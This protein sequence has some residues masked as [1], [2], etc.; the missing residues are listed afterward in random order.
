M[1]CVVVG[2]GTD[3]GKTHVTACLLAWAR[4]HAR[5]A[6]GYKPIAT[7]VDQRCEDAEAHA[8]AAG[9]PLIP[10]TFTY[11][12]PISPHLAAREE[13]RPIDVDRI[14][15]RTA[16][17][18]RE[19]DHVLVETAGGLFSPVSERL[20]NVDVALRLAPAPVLLVAPD[21]LGVLHDVG[22]CV[23]AARARGLA[24]AAI[25][26]S[27]PAVADDST[28]TNG[29]ELARLGYG[30][31]AGAFPRASIDDARS[32]TAAAGTWR[33]LLR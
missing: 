16:E 6:L 12:R 31:I 7:G 3:V 20:T 4:S 26:L 29:E 28:G 2:T 23:T 30:E 5:R 13:G 33:A 9:A 14:V 10:P 17:L 11:R 15:T 8:A 18:E 1:R 22:A 21:R 19:T 24:L 25:V 32:Q 27:A